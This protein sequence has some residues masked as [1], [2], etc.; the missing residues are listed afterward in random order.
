MRAYQ[1][2]IILIAITAFVS[3]DKGLSPDLGEEKA[4][5]G[6]SITFSGDWNPDILQTHVVVFKNP[7]LTVDDFNVFNL[8]F[9]SE[10]IPNGSVSY[11]YSTNDEN[12]LISTIEPGNISY[13]AVAQSLR[14]TITLNREDWIVVGLYYSDDDKT[15]PGILTLNEGIFIDGVNINCDFNNPPP[16]PPGGESILNKLLNSIVKDKYKLND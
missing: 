4:G 7:L 9:V 16:Q 12:A 3:C 13:I 2:F 8:S 11:N 10:S 1:I 14:D 5:F 15:M 6:G